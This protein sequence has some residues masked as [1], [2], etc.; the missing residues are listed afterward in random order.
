M[1]DRKNEGVRIS[2][3]LSEGEKR[4]TTHRKTTVKK[5]L[6]NFGI[7]CNEDEVPHIAILGAGG[8][9]RAMIALQGTLGELQN[10][11]LLD[12]VMY[13]CGVSGST[14][15][16][17]SL[18]KHWDWSDKLL[19]L[20]ERMYEM[21]LSTWSLPKAMK[22]LE[23]AAKDENYSLTD[24]WAYTVVY[25]MLHE[26]DKG[27]LSDQRA[28]S[29]NG[30]NP[31]PIY[32]AVDEKSF[33]KLSENSADTWFEFTPHEAS[34]LGHRASVDIKY[35]GSEFEG[36]E[37]KRKKEEMNMSYLQGLWGSC[38]GS[39]EENIEFIKDMLSF[40]IIER[41][42]SNS[43]GF[44]GNV[45]RFSTPSTGDEER[46]II[47]IT[48]IVH[49]TNKC[50]L[51]WK[52]GSIN[53]F[54]YKISGINSAELMEDKIIS[55][56]DAGVAINCAYPLILCPER[57][58]KLILSFDYGPGDP[59]KTLKQAVEYCRQNSIPFPEV[60][61]NLLR[62]E[63]NPS[64]VYIFRGEN[65]PTVMHF[66]LFNKVNVPGH[67]T[68]SRFKFSPVRFVYNKEDF[69]KLLQ[70]AKLNVSNNKDKILQEI[71]HVMASSNRSNLYSL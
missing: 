44:S 7:S 34:F 63:N 51:S 35:F 43:A 62:E 28:A 69:S 4:G 21:L 17:S 25:G 46:S 55:L 58:V 3:E 6:N 8:G 48:R 67:V 47:D 49:K 45:E 37:V 50:L 32:A 5:C 29:E 71:R 65:A 36:G 11:G 15:C 26:L 52:W 13:L 23:E 20:E 53:N 10:H 70:A 16:M 38:I 14:W 22:M 39:K 60:D 56:I 41:F 54:L 12:S 68:D 66:P 9:L 57:K 42:G 59:F 1:P 40:Y 31:Y 61:E 33:N 64:D 19:S 2:Q 30:K 18:Y 27:S 24:F